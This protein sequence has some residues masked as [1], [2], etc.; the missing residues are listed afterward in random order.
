MYTQAD[1]CLTTNCPLATHVYLPR[2]FR[3]TRVMINTPSITIRPSCLRNARDR[4]SNRLRYIQSDQYR[5]K[6]STDLRILP[7]LFYRSENW[8]FAHKDGQMKENTVLG[9]TYKTYTIVIIIQC[10]AGDPLETPCSLYRGPP[11]C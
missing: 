9:Y 2:C 5:S 7:T 3:L 8:T 4:S 10:N 6:S 1:V 11:K